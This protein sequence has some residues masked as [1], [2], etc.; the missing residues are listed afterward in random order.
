[1]EIERAKTQTNVA[2]AKIALTVYKEEMLWQI[3]SGI[4]NMA[5]QVGA[6]VTMKE[7]KFLSDFGVELSQ[8]RKQLEQRD[9]V[10]DFKEII[11]QKVGRSFD[12][13]V[14]QLDALTEDSRRQ[15]ERQS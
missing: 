14:S 2:L 6:D 13:F 15:R 9:L 3:R 1:L 10:D 8:F 12:R 4:S 5:A 11:R 7:L